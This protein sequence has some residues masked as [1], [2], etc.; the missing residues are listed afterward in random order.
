[1]ADL[2]WI[3]HRGR[4]IGWPD[5]DNV[6]ARDGECLFKVV[7]CLHGLHVNC[8]Q[9]LTVC[10]PNVI[11][12]GTREPVVGCP[13]CSKSP[14]ALWP[15]L[16]RLHDA[17]SIGF[18]VDHWHLHAQGTY[19]QI[20]KD[21]LLKIHCHADDGRDI[22]GIGCPD[23]MFAALYSHR[24]MLSI[25]DDKIEPDMADNLYYG[26]TPHRNENAICCLARLDS[27]LGQIFSHISSCESNVQVIR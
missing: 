12:Q 25:E 5:E 3:P 22:H 14:T 17:L 27:L 16:D 7:H 24:A 9:G 6:N 15:I 18:V 21:V 2:A 4:Q 13:Y 26:R 8:H 23:H 19:V 11:A 10:F 1:M 20:A